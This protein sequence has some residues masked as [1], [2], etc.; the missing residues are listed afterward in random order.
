M[1]DPF[2]GTQL[3]TTGVSKSPFATIDGDAAARPGA[4]SAARHSPTTLARATLRD[5]SPDTAQKV[6]TTASYRFDA[7]GRSVEANLQAV[8]QNP[9]QGRS[10]RPL[11]TVS[12]QRR[13][14]STG[15]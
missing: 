14:R 2:T 10:R 3:D 8:A 5:I 4:I 15:G 12:P 7:P 13:T 1:K 6:R 11:A 9:L